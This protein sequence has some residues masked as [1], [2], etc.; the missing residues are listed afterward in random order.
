MNPIA[1]RNAASVLPLCARIP[2]HSGFK[3]LSKDSMPYGAAAS[4]SA[5]TDNAVM[6]RTFWFS[7]AKPCSMISTMLRRCGSVAQPIRMAICCTIF[8]PVC[9]ACQLFL[10]WHTA[11]RNGRSAGTP[12]ACATTANAR[13]VV[14]RTYSS[15][16]SMSGRMAAIIVAK[17]AAFARFPMISRPSTRA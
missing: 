10:L 7:S 12:S 16:L 11:F 3:T 17:P 15:T 1:F 8:T 6:V 9:L 4:A 13:A 2:F 14:L 5:A